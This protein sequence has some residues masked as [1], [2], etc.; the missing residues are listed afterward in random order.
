MNSDWYYEFIYLNSY[1][2]ELVYMN[3]E[4]IYLILRIWIHIHELVYWALYSWIHTI[5]SCMNSYS[6]WIHVI[7]S[8]MNSYVNEFIFEFIYECMNSYKLWI[9]LIFHIYIHVSWIHIQIGW[10][11]LFTDSCWVWKFSLLFK[12]TSQH[13]LSNGSKYGKQRKDDT[14][15][16]CPMLF[17]TTFKQTL[18]PVIRL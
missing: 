13:D 9:Y 12:F 15:F 6:L 3:S 1:I 2:Y 4:S 16:A 5:I 18:S 14:T 11:W 10:L 8:Y 7:I 17:K